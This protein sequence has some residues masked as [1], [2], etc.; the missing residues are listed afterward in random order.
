ML[1]AIAVLVISCLPCALLG[2]MGLA[3]PTAIMVGVGRANK[4]WHTYKWVVLL[5]NYSVKGKK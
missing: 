3:T 4:K 2:W 5:L 1:R